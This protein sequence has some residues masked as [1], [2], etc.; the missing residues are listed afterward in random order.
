MDMDEVGKSLLEAVAKR[1]GYAGFF[2][3]PEKS[4]KEWG[5]VQT[6]REEIERERGPLIASGKQLPGGH[7]HLPPDYQLTTHSGEEWGIEVTE[8]VEQKAIEQTKRG[9]DVFAYWP[10]E[11]LQAKFTDIVGGKDRANNVSGGPFDRYVLLVHVDECMLPADRLS[12]VLGA[13]TFRTQLIDEI[14]I[15]VSYDPAIA[16]YPLVK[17][18]VIKS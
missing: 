5:I 9:V 12:A 10:D 13:M 14:Y 2:D 15:L 16:R 6:F 4:L 11:A 18:N 8:L 7:E 1:R 3:W 17:I